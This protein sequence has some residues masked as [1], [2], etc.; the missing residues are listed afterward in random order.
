MIELKVLHNLIERVIKL[1]KKDYIKIGDVLKDFKNKTTLIDNQTYDYLINA[2]G[3]ML[4]QDNLLFKWDR[5]AK[6]CK[7][8]KF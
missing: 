7:H 8:S 3:S 1:T 6:Y 2:F 4:A 5:F